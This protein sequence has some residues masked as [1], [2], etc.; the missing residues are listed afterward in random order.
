VL[1]V[2]EDHLSVRTDPQ[3]QFLAE[4]L[5]TSAKLGW[6]VGVSWLLKNI[7]NFIEITVYHPTRRT[8]MTPMKFI[9]RA[10]N[11]LPPPILRNVQLLM[12]NEQ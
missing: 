4:G 1:A 8:E 5:H 7:V 11:F 10:P 3:E 9:P 6:F 12:I 2:P